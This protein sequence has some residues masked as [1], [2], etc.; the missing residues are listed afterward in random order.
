MKNYIKKKLDKYIAKR[1][2]IAL[3]DDSV[4]N[5]IACD[6]MADYVRDNVEDAVT[7]AIGEYGTSELNERIAEI[8]D[9]YVISAQIEDVQ[10]TQSRH[11]E[12]IDNKLK[13]HLLMIKDL[14]AKCSRLQTRVTVLEKQCKDLTIQE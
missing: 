13:E 1:I 3:R 10:E 14:Q 5:K 7:E 6:I 4:V 8:E 12:G 11:Y 2:Y 9:D